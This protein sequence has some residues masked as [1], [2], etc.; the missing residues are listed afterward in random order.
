[1]FGCFDAGSATWNGKFFC[2]FIFF[3]KLF[4]I[5]FKIFV[6]SFNGNRL[7]LT[8]GNVLRNN[9]GAIRQWSIIEGFCNV[10]EQITFIVIGMDV[11]CF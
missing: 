3:L 5:S 7:C 4:S 1:M 2:I 9:F 11:V 10:S 6:C 8:F